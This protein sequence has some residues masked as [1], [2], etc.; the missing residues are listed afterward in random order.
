MSSL[1]IA[2]RRCC[3]ELVEAKSRFAL[4]GGLAVSVR[5]EPRLTRDADFGSKRSAGSLTSSEALAKI[6]CCEGPCP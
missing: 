1:E 3:D 2:L 6:K 4:I 5:S